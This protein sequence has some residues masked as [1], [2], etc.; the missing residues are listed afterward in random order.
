MNHGDRISVLLK[1]ASVIDRDQ[2]E[3]G[4]APAPE[5]AAEV[6]ILPFCPVHAV[7]VASG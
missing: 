7:G 3:N 5:I 1:A 2:P 6:T 4:S